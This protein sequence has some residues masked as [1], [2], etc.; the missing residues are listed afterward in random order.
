[1][2]GI[3]ILLLVD[4]DDVQFVPVDK[5][6]PAAAKCNRINRLREA[7]IL[8][9]AAADKQY[10]KVVLLFIF[11]F[12]EDVPVVSSNVENVDE[13]P[14]VCGVVMGNDFDTIGVWIGK[15]VEYVLEV[16]GIE[17]V[18]PDV[19]ATS[20]FIFSVINLVITNAAC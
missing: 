20:I 7:I 4:D 1:M 17:L 3:V 15:E 18:V 6:I 8:L 13:W 16:V 2:V 14:V 11:E 19:V 9:F 5:L 10:R 12:V